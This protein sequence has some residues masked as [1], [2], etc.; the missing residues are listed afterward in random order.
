MQS[1]SA[2]LDIV[3]QQECFYRVRTIASE[4]LI[5]VSVFT[6]DLIHLF[7]AFHEVPR[8]VLLS[9][10]SGLLLINLTDHFGYFNWMFPYC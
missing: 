5:R 10:K 3:C 9:F 2:L 7:A 6:H 8:P 1:K 4:C